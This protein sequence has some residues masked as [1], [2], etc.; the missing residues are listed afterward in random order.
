[1]EAC[2]KF[3]DLLPTA[4]R[5]EA[6]S[7]TM[8]WLISQEDVAA[9]DTCSNGD[10]RIR[11]KN[12]FVSFILVSAADTLPNL[13]GQARGPDY[14]VPVSAT[15][16]VGS[17]GGIYSVFRSLDKYASVIERQVQ[18][19]PAYHSLSLVSKTYLTVEQLKSGLSLSGGLFHLES[20]GNESE[21]PHLT[22]LSFGELWTPELKEKYIAMGVYRPEFL[23][24][25]S[26]PGEMPF[27]RFFNVS[28][29]FFKRFPPVAPA[30]QLNTGTMVYLSACCSDGMADEF[31]VANVK[32][33]FG[34]HGYPDVEF[35]SMVDS[36]FYDLIASDTFSASQAWEQVKDRTQGDARLV[37]R[38]LDPD[39][40]LDEY[41]ACDVGPVHLRYNA[42]TGAMLMVGHVTVAG[43]EPA[44]G[45]KV[46][47]FCPAAPGHYEVG[48]YG[49]DDAI[50]ELDD[51]DGKAC[52]AASFYIGTSGAIDVRRCES[53][54]GI[55]SMT[56]SGT[57]GWWSPGHDPVV[58]PPDLTYTI[59]NGVAK[60]LIML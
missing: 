57:V 16:L 54:G 23:S 28:D 7:Q 20:H 27:L 52:K 21:S 4:G 56:F 59:T 51:P 6:L 14:P 46:A 24:I 53:S 35:A 3:T 43:V 5:N 13:G 1:L 18:Q 58:D 36:T 41:L 49:L 25:G 39:L 8:A 19:A 60:L 42:P 29:S 44:T 33:F 30:S 12:G 15:G 45:A 31:L 2:R 9:V 17:G 22:W 50:L 32:A 55:L 34:Y 26:V 10:I 38:N 48:E 47:T 37:E 11:H 40:L